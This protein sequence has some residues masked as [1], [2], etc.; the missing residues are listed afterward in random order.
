MCVVSPERLLSLLLTHQANIP[1]GAEGAEAQ[2]LLR[3][4]EWRRRAPHELRKAKSRGA[5]L[6][7]VRAFCQRWVAVPTLRVVQRMVEGHLQERDGMLQVAELESAAG[8]VRAALRHGLD[9][10]IW[11]FARRALSW[12][13]ASSVSARCA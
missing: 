9:V 8:Q 6:N 5:Q 12:R 11:T 7:A 2:A 13:R 10:L 4:Q 1:V 3:A